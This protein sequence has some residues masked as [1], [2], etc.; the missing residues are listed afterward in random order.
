M[1]VADFASQYLISLGY[2]YRQAIAYL[3]LAFGGLMAKEILIP[4]V[5]ILLG[6]FV[7][8]APAQ[9]ASCS[10]TNNF[11]NGQ[12]ADANLVNQNFSD[13][14]NC[15]LPKTDPYFNGNVGI[16]TPS[17][18]SILTIASDGNPSVSI[19]GTD[20]TPGG[21][22][23]RFYSDGL[24]ANST[25]VVASYNNSTGH[26]FVLGSAANGP[27]RVM[28]N[29]LPRL[30]ISAA[31]NTYFGQDSDAS[32]LLQVASN[33]AGKP[34]GGSWSDTSDR[35]LKTNVATLD[36]A[37]A[38]AKLQQLRPVTFSWVNPRVHANDGVP[39]GFIAQEIA[40]VFPEFVGNIPCE[41]ADC[42]LVGGAGRSEYDL[43]L[44]FKFDAYVVAS[45]Q[46]L[47]K[48]VVELKHRTSATVVGSLP[49]SDK[50]SSAEVIAELH[51]QQEM[52]RS[53][54]MANDRQTNEIRQL[55]AQRSVDIEHLQTQFMALQ[56][57]LNIQTA[58]K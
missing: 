30:H 10:V 1:H 44:P 45:I 9:A 40:R 27:V 11:T 32:Y 15:A 35:R 25:G 14:A 28:T 20:G 26:D 38:L 43:N 16:G 12:T 5:L 56:R 7:I 31:G 18:I 52:I 33:S 36:G 58:Q 39:G 17:P 47:G 55:Q 24:A 3:C 29:G 50:N 23:I 22:A 8:S 4:S 46:Q 6:A 49:A 48:E 2:N 34:G 37:T 51:I 13:L 41:G 57:R 54:K 21:P 42:A 19:A 53:L